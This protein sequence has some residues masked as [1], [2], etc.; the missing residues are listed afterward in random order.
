M[1]TAP[2]LK[3]TLVRSDKVNLP[4]PDVAPVISKETST[5]HPAGPP[6]M[7]LKPGLMQTA[8]SRVIVPS[9]AAEP[10]DVQTSSKVL[11]TADAGCEVA[12]SPVTEAAIAHAARMP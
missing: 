8:S 9:A 7:S 10:G 2:V 3:R 12:K 5:K 11:T 4:F 6:T 1:T